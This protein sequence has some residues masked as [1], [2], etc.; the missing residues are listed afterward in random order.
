MIKLDDYKDKIDELKQQGYNTKQILKIIK[1]EYRSKAKETTDKRPKSLIQKELLEDFWLFVIWLDERDENKPTRPPLIPTKSQLYKDICRCLTQ[2]SKRMIIALPRK[3]RKSYLIKAYI[4]WYLLNHPNHN[5]NLISETLNLSTDSLISIKS[6]LSY[7]KHVVNLFG[8]ELLASIGNN[9]RKLT[10]RLRNTHKSGFNVYCWGMSNAITGKRSDIVIFDDIIGETFK[11]STEHTKQ[12]TI[13]KFY[14]VFPT[15]ETYSKVIYIGTRWCRGDLIEIIQDKDNL[16]E[17]SV[18][19]ESVYDENRNPKF[20]EVMDKEEIELQKR[21]LPPAFFAA[22]YENKIVAEENQ[23]FK[24]DEYL[25]Y[26]TLN[27][28]D[29]KYMIMG[30]DLSL[31]KGGDKNAL[32]IIGINDKSRVFVIDAFGNNQIL[33]DK[34]YEKI[35]EYY[36]KYK[37]KIKIVIVEAIGGFQDRYDRFKERNRNFSHGIPFD[38]VKGQST[39]KN[40]RL[41]FILEPAFRSEKLLL[42]SDLIVKQVINNNYINKGLLDL[43]E[44][45]RFF[46]I[47]NQ[48]SNID[49]MI[50]ALALAV[51][52][53]NEYE[54][55]LSYSPRFT[56]V[57]TNNSKKK[58]YGY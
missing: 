1:E 39:S 38:A 20:P 48:N 4:I 24:V 11:D 43:I 5:I 19:I 25:R 14:S 35:R 10:L 42:P 30:V 57:N 21:T 6:I 46:D 56:S 12:K 18:F 52:K 31:G 28:D 49:D 58:K 27:F 34:F 40:A 26:D 41:E 54:D 29:I 47:K 15:L 7:N 23:I 17:W 8:A 3:F 9:E 53:L 22:Q 32:V 37:S 36:N 16:N 13:N 55:T 45:L 33:L 51:E 50:D 2:D 44:E